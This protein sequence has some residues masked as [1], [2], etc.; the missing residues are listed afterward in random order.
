MDV[1]WFLINE[2]PPGLG[3]YQ[4]LADAGLD[5]RTSDTDLPSWVP[6]WWLSRRRTREI[7]ASTFRAGGKY[8]SWGRRG[9][10]DDI[11]EV[12]GW[13]F[14]EYKDECGTR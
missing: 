9:A 7:V 3:L 10:N 2:N 6:Q 12:D 11:L 13:V 8:I 1:A 5:P 14:A 4:V